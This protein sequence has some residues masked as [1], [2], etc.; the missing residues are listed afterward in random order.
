MTLEDYDATYTLWYN[1]EGMGLSA[2]DSREGIRQFLER[3]PGLS[4]VAEDRPG[5]IATVLCGHDGRRGFLH[6]LAVYREYRGKGIGKN[7]V[8][9]A[10][11]KL[12]A[13][14]IQKCHIFIH[15]D[16]SSGKQFWQKLGWQSRTE[17][18]M[19]SKDVSLG[20]GPER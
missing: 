15:Q 16:N 10:L 5:I 3:N 11:A 9:T 13:A 6:H 17:L 12:A 4:L 20:S 19:M 14:G 7:L 8:E 1:T 18:K 2:A